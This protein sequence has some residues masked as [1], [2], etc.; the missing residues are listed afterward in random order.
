MA[1]FAKLLI[2]QQAFIEE[3]Q[4]QILKINGAIYGGDRFNKSGN[5]VRPDKPGFY[6]GSDGVFKATGGVFQ[7]VSSGEFDG[8]VHGDYGSFDVL[9]TKSFEMLNGGPLAANQDT[10]YSQQRS[11]ANN[12]PVKTVMND[13]FSLGIKHGH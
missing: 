9:K 5:V 7:G 10:F 1:L 8:S 11:Y 13:E 3:L 12:T 6:L 4:S 2:A